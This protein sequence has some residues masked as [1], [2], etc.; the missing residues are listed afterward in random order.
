MPSERS[1]FLKHLLPGKGRDE[2][3]KEGEKPANAGQVL[4]STKP[5]IS[6]A[7]KKEQAIQAILVA[8]QDCK[9]QALAL[10][11]QAGKIQPASEMLSQA[12]KLLARA[13]GVQ[14]MEVAEINEA[15]LNEIIEQYKQPERPAEVATLE[16]LRATTPEGREI[17]FDLREQRKYWSDYYREQG[18]DWVSLPETIKVGEEQAREMIK[19][20]EQGCDKMIIMPENLVDEPEITTDASGKPTGMKNEKYEKLHE[21]MSQGYVTTFTG[22]NY[23]QDGKFQGSQDKTTRLRIILTKD[24]QNLEDDPLFKGTLGKSIE[25]L[26]KDELTRFTGFAESSYLVFQREYYKRTG[27]HLDEKGVT[28][29]PE[30]GRLLSGRVAHASWNPDDGRLHFGS[31]SRARRNDGLGCRLAGSFVIDL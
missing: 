21:L 13:M 26:E 10:R 20:M 7:Q 5:E 18:P 16:T 17:S 29:L 4:E 2:T 3:A 24:V 12:E 9:K 15:E 23:N 11:Q 25:D 31:D 28:W 22:S 6:L 27:K 19:L 14:S 1:N 8:Y 30:S